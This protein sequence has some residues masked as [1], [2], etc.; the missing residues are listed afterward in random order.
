MS[1]RNGA[2]A[3]LVLAL[4]GLG[5]AA[6]DHRMAF[7]RLYALSFSSPP[8]LEPGQEN[9]ETVWFDDYFTV[10]GIDA[11]TFAIGEPRF[12]Q[13]NYNYLVVGSERA[14]LFD[15]GPGVRDIRPVVAS[16]TDLP[17]VAVPS[18]LHYDHI[19]NH[20][21]FDQ[22]GVVDLPE[23]R[24]RAEAHGGILRPTPAEH[25]GFVEDIPIPDLRVTEW[26]TP[27]SDID[28]GGRTLR[29]LH[30]PGHTRDSISLFDAAR[31]QLFTGDYVTEGALYA[32]IPG[33]SLAD[34]LATANALLDVLPESVQLLT[35]HRFTPPGPPILRYEDLQNLQT[36]L[37]AIRS[38]ELQATG[39]YP[40]VYRVNDD[41]EVHADFRW[42]QQW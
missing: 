18:H 35:A 6:R 9:P 28:L 29:V 10:E 1:L 25:L 4:A 20:V 2:L 39:T 14:L 41:L 40:R 17:V 23:F 38:G 8:L 33:A 27:G 24:T 32:F 42:G 22:I 16:L 36:A 5:L 26:L 7:T 15:S 19:G 12:Y 3:L 13:G 31:D 37:L 21:L 34:F 11:D 30:T